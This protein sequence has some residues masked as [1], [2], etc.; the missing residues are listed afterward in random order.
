MLPPKVTFYY[1]TPDHLIADTAVGYSV[2]TFVNLF[3]FNDTMT[4]A[5]HAAVKDILT[6]IPSELLPLNNKEIGISNVALDGGFT[7][8]RTTI[9]G[10]PYEWKFHD[11][12]GSA[13]SE[14]KQFVTKAR[15]VFQ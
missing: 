2:P 9:G 11:D 14:I 6:S 3:N 1:L 15:S 13:S 4:A 10:N 12:L 8:V 5:R 7:L